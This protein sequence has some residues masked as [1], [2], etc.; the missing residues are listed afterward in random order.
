MAQS[1]IAA[2]TNGCSALLSTVL[3]PAT[4]PDAHYVVAQ[5]T[6]VAL[7][8]MTVNPADCRKVPSTRLKVDPDTS[9]V[10]GAAFHCDH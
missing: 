8:G 4:S 2:L 5:N 7:E 10:M 6:I 3:A 1:S 9:V